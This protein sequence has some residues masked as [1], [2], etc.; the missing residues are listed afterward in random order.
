MERET[1]GR[2][3]GRWMSAACDSVLFAEEQ[4]ATVLRISE[5]VATR[6][7]PALHPVIRI[8]SASG[9][10]TRKSGAGACSYGLE[11]SRRSRRI[12]KSS[13]GIALKE[14]SIAFSFVHS[15]KESYRKTSY[16]SNTVHF[17]WVAVRDGA[18]T[19]REFPASGV[20]LNVSRHGCA[21]REVRERVRLVPCFWIT[22]LRAGRK[23]VLGYN[24]PCL[25]AP[26]R[27]S[28][29]SIVILLVAQPTL[30]RSC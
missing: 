13:A 12:E 24:P 21:R 29:S 9:N 8:V 20:D 18:Q 26:A 30:R 23:P 17:Y 28:V 14:V 3:S 25:N 7:R 27:Q 11:R 16:S 6:R 2:H 22:A 1:C 4:E 10:C 19:L 5:P 15:Q